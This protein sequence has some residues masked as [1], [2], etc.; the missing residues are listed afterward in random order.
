[1]LKSNSKLDR[2]ALHEEYR[3]EKWLQGRAGKVWVPKFTRWDAYAGS[4]DNIRSAVADMRSA[5][6]LS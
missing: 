5:I 4:S 6:A 3:T 1:M 2:G